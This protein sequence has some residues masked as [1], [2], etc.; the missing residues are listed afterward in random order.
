MSKSDP[1]ITSVHVVHDFYGC[2]CECCGHWVYG[3]D[4]DGHRIKMAWNFDHP[5]DGQHREFIQE[6]AQDSFPG[7]EIDYDRCEV[8]DNC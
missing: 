2:E 6:L 5:V 1:R 4:K 8:T 7:I 3:C